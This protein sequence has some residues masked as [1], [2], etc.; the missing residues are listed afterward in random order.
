MESYV[1]PREAQNSPRDHAW[2]YAVAGAFVGA[3]KLSWTSLWSWHFVTRFTLFA[4]LD[5]AIVTLF[6]IL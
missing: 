4:E 5:L 6:L 2:Q 1:G 3:G